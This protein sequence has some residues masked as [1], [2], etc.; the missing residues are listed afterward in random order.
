METWFL[1][2]S[3]KRQRGGLYLQNMSKTSPNA[4]CDLSSGIWMCPQCVLDAF[5]PVLCCLLVIRSSRTHVG[6]RQKL[7][8]K[9]AVHYTSCCD[10]KLPWKIIREWHPQPCLNVSCCI[11][12][13]E[14]LM[15]KI[16]TDL[17]PHVRQSWG[18]QQGNSY[19]IALMLSKLNLHFL[20]KHQEITF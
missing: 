9:N 7:P 19:Y 17:Q 20:Y 10:F 12:K 11:F 3:N 6:P 14:E 4:K 5:T 8:V 13:R 1:V 16:I 2:K 15:L 18:R